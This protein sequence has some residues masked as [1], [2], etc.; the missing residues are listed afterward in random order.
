MSETK[1]YTLEEVAQH[2]EKK[3]VWVIIHDAVYDVTPFLDEVSLHTSLRIAYS[4]AYH[5]LFVYSI[6]V[7][8]RC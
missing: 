7:A 5:L 4:F 1:T 3:S 6:L 8:R 2:N